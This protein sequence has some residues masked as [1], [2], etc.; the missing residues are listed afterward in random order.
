MITVDFILQELEVR[1]TKLTDFEGEAITRGDEDL[2]NRLTS[3]RIELESIYGWI[4]A[5]QMMK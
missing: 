2:L 4:K 3:R 5:R 1:I